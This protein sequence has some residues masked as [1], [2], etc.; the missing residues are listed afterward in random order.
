MKLRN[1]FVLGLFV[2][3]AYSCTDLTET[4]NDDLTEE[5]AFE[6]ADV[7]AL[8]VGAYRDL[9]TPFQDQANFWAAQKTLLSLIWP[10]E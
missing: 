1:L 7:D 6:A 4:I 9:F 3:G 5:Q 10:L 2:F 8:L